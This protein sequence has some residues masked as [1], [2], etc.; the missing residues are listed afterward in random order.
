MVFRDDFR[1]EDFSLPVRKKLKERRRHFGIE[2]SC[3]MSRIFP[4][5][6]H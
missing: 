3:R 5:A 4:F 2:K 1:K 6:L